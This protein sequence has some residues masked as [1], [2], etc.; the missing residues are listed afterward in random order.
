MARPFKFQSADKVWQLYQ[1]YLTDLQNQSL[2]RPEVI[3]SGERC[4][5]IIQVE[6]KVPPT[7][8]GFCLFID[9]DKV[10]YYNYVS[11]DSENIDRELINI[12]TRVDDDIKNKQITGATVNMYNGAIVA[13]LNG[14]NDTINVGTSEN[15]CINIQIGTK[16]LSLN[17]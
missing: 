2:Y 6:I 5:D 12:F 8:L 11:V 1:E 3:K 14:L 16:D 10:T 15:S 13:R 4:G 17:K 9:I 7:V